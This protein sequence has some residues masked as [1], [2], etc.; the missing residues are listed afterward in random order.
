MILKN[1][2]IS[3]DRWELSDK[4]YDGIKVLFDRGNSKGYFLTI[5][6]EL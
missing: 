2:A 4:S 1:Y 3:L 6:M 5:N